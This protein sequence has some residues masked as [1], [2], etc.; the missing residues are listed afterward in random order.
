M[1]K[2]GDGAFSFGRSCPAYLGAKGK[3]GPEEFVVGRGGFLPVGGG[4]EKG[5]FVF[6]ELVTQKKTEKEGKVPVF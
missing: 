5:G 6:P 4:Q 2:K 3:A 1:E